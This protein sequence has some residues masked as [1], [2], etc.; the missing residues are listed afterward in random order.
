MTAW[1]ERKTAVG[2]TQDYHMLPVDGDY[3]CLPLDFRL[4]CFDLSSTRHGANGCVVNTRLLAPSPWKHDCQVVCK[5]VDV[6]CYPNAANLLHKE[7]CAYA[8]LQDLQGKV[9]PTLYGF[10]KVWG[11]LWFLALEPVGKAIPEDEQIHPTLRKKMKVALQSIYDAG[12]VHG[13]VTC[14]NFCR[15]EHGDIFMV[16]LETCHHSGNLSELG[17]EMNEVDQL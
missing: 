13:D 3:Q 7:A 2:N 14:C 9:I 5:V 11:I 1:K 4:C 12:F 8:A 17:N 10:Y 6:L 16:D 15:T